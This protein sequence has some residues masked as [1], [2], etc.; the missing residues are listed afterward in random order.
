MFHFR[1]ILL[2]WLFLKIMCARAHTHIF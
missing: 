1:N 2:S